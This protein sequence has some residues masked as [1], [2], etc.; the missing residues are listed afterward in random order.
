MPETQ[1]T[2][3]LSWIEAKAVAKGDA[4][5]IPVT[6]LLT[7]P[8]PVEVRPSAA[9]ASRAAQAAGPH[10]G[11]A[12]A[13]ALVAL[14]HCK[15]EDPESVIDLYPADRILDVCY[16]ALH[17]KHTLKSKTGFIHQ[18]LTLGWEVRPRRPK[19]GQRKERGE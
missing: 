4:R 14:R 19:E 1:L 15:F 18:A 2:V 17:Y 7:T 5:Q 3:I 11:G 16:A 13:F 9:P 12:R 6:I 10:A 8:P